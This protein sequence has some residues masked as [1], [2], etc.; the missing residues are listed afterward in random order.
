MGQTSLL[1]RLEWQQLRQD[2]VDCDAMVLPTWLNGADNFA[3]VIASNAGSILNAL[4]TA[5]KAQLR[6]LLPAG[7]DESKDALLG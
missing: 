3:E 2:M 5:D 4:T 1:P 7:D 6:D